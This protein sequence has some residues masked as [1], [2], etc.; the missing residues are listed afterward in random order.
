MRLSI[1]N[2]LCSLLLKL[3][4]PL[5]SVQ[6]CLDF[7]TNYLRSL[8]AVTNEYVPRLFLAMTI[9]VWWVLVP[10]VNSSYQVVWR[11]CWFFFLLKTVFCINR[12]FLYAFLFNNYGFQCVSLSF[13]LILRRFSRKGRW[14]SAQV[15]FDYSELFEARIVSFLS[16]YA[17]SRKIEVMLLSLNTCRVTKSHSALDQM[18]RQITRVRQILALGYEI[19]ISQNESLP[20]CLPFAITVSQWTHK[21]STFF[22]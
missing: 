19:I 7:A 4:Y 10:S 21:F 16:L 8:D 14:S 3:D 11:T 2:F 18:K 20:F 6:C 13:F 9:A 15:W 17:L 5:Q 22:F 12:Q 1:L